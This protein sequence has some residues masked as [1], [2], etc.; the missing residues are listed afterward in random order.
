MRFSISVI[1]CTHNPRHHYLEKVL[2]AL[3][4]QTL[5]LKQW[6]FLLIDNASEQLLSSEIDLNW[7]PNARHIREEKLGL[8][9]ARLRGIQEAVGDILVFVDDDNVLDLDYLEITLKISKDFAIIGAWG[10]Q[11]IPELE[12]KPPEWIKTDQK[13]YLYSLACREFD[14]DSWSNLLHQHTTTPCGAGLCVRK[15]VADKYAESIRN[16]PRR[17]GMGRKGN[18]LTSCEDTDLAFTACDIGLGT[19]QFTSLKVTH[20]IPPSRLEEH[21]LLRLT[22]GLSYSGTMLDYM[23]GKLPP[24]QTWKSSKIYLLYLRL[25]YGVRRS[26][27][28]EATQKGI[29]LALKEI[30]N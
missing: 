26:R 20:L 15:I 6:E 1:T 17:I 10:G 22:E 12:E 19:G 28:Y 27:F 14:R 3:K 4:S 5:P 18:L 16:D 29:R 23:R 2:G 8:T 21:Y 13:N 30:A 7:H 9:P 25:R 24:Q 11:V